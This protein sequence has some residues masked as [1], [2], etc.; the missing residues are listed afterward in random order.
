MSCCWYFTRDWLINNGRYFKF[1]HTQNNISAKTFMQKLNIPKIMQNQTPLYSK[2]DLGLGRF[3]QTNGRHLLASTK[4]II[5][6][7]LYDNKYKL[8]F[9][10]SS[11]NIGSITGRGARP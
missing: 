9:S 3:Q 10:A 2:N 5:Y 7:I 4:D 6:K 11:R 8:Q 1:P